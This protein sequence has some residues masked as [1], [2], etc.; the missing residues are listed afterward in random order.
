MF[1]YRRQ[2]C[3]TNIVVCDFSIKCGKRKGVNSFWRASVA[4]SGHKCR[5][6]VHSIKCISY[7][8]KISF[9]EKIS[10]YYHLWIRR[11]RSHQKQD[12]DI[13]MVPVLIFVYFGWMFFLHSLKLLSILMGGGTLR[14][15][16]G[17]EAGMNFSWT[18]SGHTRESLLN[19]CAA[20]VRYTYSPS[21]ED[22]SLTHIEP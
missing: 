14:R 1:L 10:G 22:H 20:R 6:T 12:P 17:E 21:A 3:Y 5:G 7:G 4:C 8:I 16:T 11:S 9:C 19:H 15:A 2:V 13:L 18:H